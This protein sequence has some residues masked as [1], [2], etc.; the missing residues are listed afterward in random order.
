MADP[1]GYDEVPYPS[2]PYPYTHPDHLATLATLFG[3]EAAA[4]E[5]GRVL[6]VGCADGANLIPMALTLP[7]A[8]W[9]G[10]DLSQR[11]IA[12][13]RRMIDR[14]KLTSRWLARRGIFHRTR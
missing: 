8:R 12:A 1:Y 9:V 2:A 3:L 14:L 13:G 4:V 5:D 10:I 6:E 7:R 11:Q